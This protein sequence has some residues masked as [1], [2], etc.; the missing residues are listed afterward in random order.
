MAKE[1]PPQ[2]GEGGVEGGSKNGAGYNLVA[3]RV[4]GETRAKLDELVEISGLNQSELLRRLVMEAVV[5]APKFK[6]NLDRV[7]SRQREGRARP[8]KKALDET[9]AANGAAP[10]ATDEEGE[11]EV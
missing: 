3:F 1:E 5:Q 9:A 11:L 2:D 8:R 10:G 6:L 4:E 7:L